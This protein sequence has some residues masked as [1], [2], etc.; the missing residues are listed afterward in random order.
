[1]RVM[2]LIPSSV[3]DEHCLSA[4]GVLNRNS[5]SNI[6]PFCNIASRSSDSRRDLE[7]VDDHACI[8]I[9]HVMTIIPFC[10]NDGDFLS[11][12]VPVELA[13]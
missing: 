10:S 4:A 3:Q 1:M 7:A 6:Y 9:M 12:L 11:L 13:F 5:I 2:I 8:R